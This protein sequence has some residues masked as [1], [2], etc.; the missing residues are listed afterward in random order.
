MDTANT[1][2][3]FLRISAL[4]GSGLALTACGHQVA[5]EK[6]KETKNQDEEC[7]GHGY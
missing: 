7:R 3:Q 2:R 5:Q 4:A 6:T 1:R